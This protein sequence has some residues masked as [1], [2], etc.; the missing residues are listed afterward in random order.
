MAAYAGHG[1]GA[2]LKDR[3][4]GKKASRG[5][6]NGLQDRV[7]SCPLRFVFR[8]RLL[9][10]GPLNRSSREP[11]GGVTPQTKRVD[12]GSKV[13]GKVAAVRIVAGNASALCIGRML[14]RV[15]GFPMAGETDLIF[16]HRQTDRSRHAVRNHLMAERA[17]HHH[18][19][20]HHAAA[21]LV[22]VTG[23]TI[24]ACTKG[25]RFDPLRL[26]SAR[27]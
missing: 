15:F 13:H 7:D 26:R 2:V 5:M 24:G 1:L 14:V 10:A 11:L 16:W 12:L 21:G 8:P 4:K 17:P 6:M 19:G 3:H 20:M 18:R 9:I 25:V 27:E 22:R 23:R